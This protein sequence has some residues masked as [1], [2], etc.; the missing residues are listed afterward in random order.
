MDWVGP[1]DGA[2]PV[3]LGAAVAVGDGVFVGVGDG[4][5]GFVADGDVVG[6]GVGFGVGF[7][8]GL[9][10]GFG[11][12]F[13]LGF[14]FLAGALMDFFLATFFFVVGPGSLAPFTFAFALVSFGFG[15]RFFLGFFFAVS[16]L[17]PIATAVPSD[18]Q[19]VVLMVL[20]STHR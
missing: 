9:G 8:L 1:V 10:V 7:G 20:A 12:G 19:N 16:R 18:P 11:V 13:G 4:D 6:L 2:G 17:P 14:G 3:G 15:R 5:G